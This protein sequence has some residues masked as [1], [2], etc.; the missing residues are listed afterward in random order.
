MIRN[1]TRGVVRALHHLAF[2]VGIGL[3]LVAAA[4]AR[5]V[6]I[7]ARSPHFEMFSSASEGEA[8]DMLNKLE[9]FRT[10][11]LAI[12]SVPQ[13]HDP[14]TTIVFF[15]TGRQFD[16]CK[17]LR[18][19]KPADA[20]GYC[21]GGPDET[22]I[23]MA[24]D[25]NPEK[26]DEAVFRG[27]LRLML[28]AGGA[29]P[30]LWLDEGLAEL[31]ST[32][33]IEGDSFVLGAEKPVPVETLGRMQLLPPGR[34]FAVTP[35]LPERGGEAFR[36]ESW[37]LVHFMVCG[38]DSAA[39]LPRL[40]RFNELNATTD[41][42]AD[43]SFQEAFGV[44][45]AEMEQEIDRYLH[46]G[47]FLAQR[48]RLIQGDSSARSEFRPAE[49]Y[50]RNLALMNLRWR[51]QAPADTVYQ[52]M[53]LSGDHPDAPR[54][55]EVIAAMALRGGDRKDALGHWRSAADL[56]SDNPYVY[57]QL[58]DDGLD[59][60][61]IGLTLD[62]RMPA[63]LAATLRGWLDRAI[64]LSPRYL[65]A[66][67]ALAVVEAFSEQPRLETANRIQEV[68]PKMRDRTRAMF[69]I[70]ILRA[71]MGDHATARQIARSLLAVPNIQA[72]IRFLMQRLN[73][74]LGPAETPAAP[75]PDA[76][77]GLPN[78]R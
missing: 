77:E 5:E 49:D 55:H 46:G 39:W 19:G 42:A 36:V 31:F 76:V 43:R 34:L 58:A 53:Q 35:E 30:P 28:A 18:D 73:W 51:L 20:A 25:N 68:V 60:F 67:Q 21:V 37:A 54:P 78:P 59:Q 75:A 10:A 62:T 72:R 66:Y 71:R 38:K 64:A 1:F 32:F 70:A 44:D 50:E 52:V 61:S 65:D 9:Q 11:V 41:V 33:R 4:S 16:S 57:L 8:R 22:V 47:H 2:L 40:R 48:G 63:E 29:E 13:Y 6:W 17:P 3:A 45:Y 26:T 69:A 15:A 12:C 23:A 24:A 27:Y 56:G 14:K 74:R 7:T